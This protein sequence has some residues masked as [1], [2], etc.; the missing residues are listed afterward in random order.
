M[1]VESCRSLSCSFCSS[2][3]PSMRGML[4]SLTTMSISRFAV[5]QRQRLDAVA[6]E[7][8]AD[9][10]VADLAAEFLHDQRLEVG[11][12]V[13]DEDTRG[14]AAIPSRVSISPRSAAKSIGLV[15]SASA[16]LSSALRL[17]S[18]SP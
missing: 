7:Q 5:D 17:V 8:E 14:H 11:L 9:R 12:V 3:S 4:M 10:A 15:S 16:P 6:R 2:D 13:D 18:A 1:M